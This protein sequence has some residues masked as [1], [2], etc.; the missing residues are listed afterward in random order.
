LNIDGWNGIISVSNMRRRISIWELAFGVKEPGN[1]KKPRDEEKYSEIFDRYDAPGTL[2]MGEC[3]KRALEEVGYD[4]VKCKHCNGT[5]I[6][7]D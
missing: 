5:G 4:L 1:S 6:Q 7:K 3:R 2:S